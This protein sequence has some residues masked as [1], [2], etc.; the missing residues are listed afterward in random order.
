MRGNL[1]GLLAQAQKMQK[2]VERIQAE[3]GNLEVVGESGAGLVKITM[4]CKHEARKVE[5]DPSLLTGEP[6]DKEMLED[7]V[8]AALNDAAH[9][10]EET[11]QA[12]MRQATAGMPLP[13]G[14]KLF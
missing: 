4:T 9:K 13:P 7:L 3:L 8:A 10:V 14:M 6:D 5:I 12:K 11:T 1:Q 2:N